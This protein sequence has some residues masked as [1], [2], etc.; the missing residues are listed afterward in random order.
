MFDLK[1][2]TQHAERA[3]PNES[4]GVIVESVGYVPCENIDLN[5]TVAFSMNPADFVRHGTVVAVVH[6]H[7]N[8]PAY[9]SK[10]DMVSQ[11]TSGVP[12]AVISVTPHAGKP[13]AYDAFWFGD[14]V[15][16][17]S[18]D[19]R[20]FRHGVTDC[21]ALIRDWY[22]GR[23]ILLPEHPRDWEWWKRGERLYEDL[24]EPTGFREVV[25]KT[26]KAGDVFLCRIMSKTANHAGV[27]LD[28]GL[29]LHHLAAVSGFDPHQLS[30]KEPFG[31]WYNVTTTI[32][33][34]EGWM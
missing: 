3:F 26:P 5:P 1:E 31:R 25:T 17:P 23:N 8:G 22:K 27:F 34:Y 21:Y 7:P 12:W 30:R 11:Q 18:L 32:A 2:A 33:R 13:T 6:S 28:N 9:P 10:S 16:T 20:G 15:P 29:V 4:C 14:Q 19:R 24:L